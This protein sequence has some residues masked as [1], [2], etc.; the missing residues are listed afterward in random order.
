MAGETL[1]Y[2][3]VLLLSSR[4]ATRGQSH[5]YLKSA[6]FPIHTLKVLPPATYYSGPKGSSVLSQSRESTVTINVRLHWWCFCLPCVSLFQWLKYLDRI[7]SS[8]RK[9]RPLWKEKITSVQWCCMFL[10]GS[11]SSGEN[12]SVRGATCTRGPTSRIAGRTPEST[13]ASVIMVCT[14]LIGAIKP[15]KV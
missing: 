2:I 8:L 12:P 4:R 3:I 9:G 15:A 13:C 14:A 10:F 7:V 1:L 11:I 6:I 5:T